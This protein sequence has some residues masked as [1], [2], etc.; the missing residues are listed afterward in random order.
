MENSITISFPNCELY[1]YVYVFEI[2]D[3]T[4]VAAYLKFKVLNLIVFHLEN[5]FICASK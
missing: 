2:H 3:A 4:Y 1:T 5:S